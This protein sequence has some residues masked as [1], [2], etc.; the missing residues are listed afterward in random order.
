MG[1]KERA[2]DAAED[3]CPTPSPTAEPTSTKPCDPAED[4]SCSK[5][6]KSSTTTTSTTNVS[7]TTT[8]TSNQLTSSTG[9]AGMDSTTSSTTSAQKTS[10]IF[11]SINSLPITS[12]PPTITAAPDAAAA[13]MALTHPL[14]LSTQT[15][16]IIVVLVLVGFIIIVP[17]MFF[18]IRRSYLR[19]QARKKVDG[20]PPPSPGYRASYSQSMRSENLPPTSQNEPERKG[21]A[22]GMIQ[23]G[24]SPPTLLTAPRGRT[25]SLGNMKREDPFADQNTGI[26]P[27]VRSNTASGLLQEDPFA[28]PVRI[29]NLAARTSMAE[30]TMP[31]SI[32]PSKILLHSQLQEKPAPLT[33]IYPDMEALQYNTVSG[34]VELPESPFSEDF[35]D[36]LNAPQERPDE[37]QSKILNDETMPVAI[38]PGGRWSDPFTAESYRASGIVDSDTDRRKYK[39]PMSWVKDQAGRLNPDTTLEPVTMPLTAYPGSGRPDVIGTAI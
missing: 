19:Q 34:A 4:D 13:S 7:V 9:I 8:S 29:E 10:S 21:S 11:S 2:C 18:L 17:T 15:Q 35:R 16:A 31:H 23:A 3:A 12:S 5:T 38:S 37:R 27:L 30:D 26:T 1:L 36:S 14:G 33:V 25:I 39:S 6:T 22:T 32:V 24:I 28:D 20:A